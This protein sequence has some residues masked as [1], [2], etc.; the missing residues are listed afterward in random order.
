MKEIN[1]EKIINIILI[2]TVFSILFFGTKYIDN[3]KSTI[4][5]NQI[6]L[7]E[8]AE[9][10]RISAENMRQLE[11]ELNALNNRYRNLTENYKRTTDELGQAKLTYTKL[12][13]RYDEVELINKQ[14]GEDKLRLSDTITKLS[15]RTSESSIDIN[16]IRTGL[17]RQSEY[18]RAI[19]D[20]VKEIETNNRM[21]R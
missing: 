21:E 12:E 18:I 10:K 7:G 8:F 1:N 14:L 11:I 15:T 9:G 6:K 3:L 5:D 4:S 17:E 19:T 2:F 13:T 16:Q 20:T